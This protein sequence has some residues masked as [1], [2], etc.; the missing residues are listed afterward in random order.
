MAR[1]NFWYIIFLYYPHYSPTYPLIFRPR[2]YFLYIFKFLNY[3]SK[4]RELFLCE[5]FCVGVCPGPPPI[6]IHQKVILFLYFYIVFSRE[7][8]V[9]SYNKIFLS[10]PRTRICK[11][12]GEKTFTWFFKNSWSVKIYRKF[13]SLNTHMADIL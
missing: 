11:K 4:I 8:W 12:Y 13:K 1:G 10:S 9:I 7:P 2:H 3:F 6:Q 5:N